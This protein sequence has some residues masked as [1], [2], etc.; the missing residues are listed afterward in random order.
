MTECLNT[1]FRFPIMLHAR[2]INKIIKRAPD[3][4]AIVLG[5]IPWEGM[6]LISVVIIHFM[7]SDDF[8]N[9]LRSDKKIKHGVMFRYS[10]RNIPISKKSRFEPKKP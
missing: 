4:I 9:F 3:L 10:I 7:W 1:S 2:K 8:F 5:L 6:G